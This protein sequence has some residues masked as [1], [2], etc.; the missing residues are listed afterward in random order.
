MSLHP[1]R[2]CRFGLLVLLVLLAGCVALSVSPDEQATPQAHHERAGLAIQAVYDEALPSLSAAKRRHYAQRLYRLTGE[3]RYLDDNRAYG[4]RL[5]NWLERDLAGLEEPDYVARRSQELLSRH[6]TGTPRQRA[7]RVMFEEWGEMIFARELLFRLVQAQYHGLLGEIDG[8][9]R[10]LAYLAGLDWRRFLTDPHVLGVYSAQVA[11]QAHF[12]HQLGVADL[13]REVTDAFRERYHPG[14]AEGLGRTEYHNKL[15]GMT[16]FMIAAS[17]YYQRQVSAEEFDWVLGA[18]ERDLERILA[19]ATE[20]ILAEVALCF[21]LA[22][23]EA[24]PAVERIRDALVEAVDAEAGIIPSPVG[25]LDLEGGEHR[26]VLAIM[27]L[28]WTGRL[29]PGPLLGGAGD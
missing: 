26:N 21:L 6:L 3:E 9:E 19:R 23:Q 7:R 15:Y 5:V 4:R 10:G 28:R 27:V 17:R 1:L 11:N 24:H 20:D 18:F 29:H 16:H 2:W 13:R 22:G 12:L 25:S 14:S 8:H